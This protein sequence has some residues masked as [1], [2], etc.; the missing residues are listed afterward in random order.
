[1]LILVKINIKLKMF[2]SD[3]IQVVMGV[4]KINCL[5]NRDNNIKEYLVG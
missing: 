5:Q 3:I 2:D 4:A 1:M